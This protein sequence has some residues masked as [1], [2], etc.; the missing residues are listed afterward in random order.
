MVV[1]KL[2]V[3][4]RLATTLGLL[5]LGLLLSWSGDGTTAELPRVVVVATDS[6][7]GFGERV[8][9]ELSLM[10]FDVG[11]ETAPVSELSKEE[12]EQKARVQSAAAIIAI[13][14]VKDGVELRVVDRVTKK[15]LLRNIIDAEQPSDD[16]TV[17]LRAVELLRASLLELSVQDAP[18]G[19]VA[20]P[21]EARE[22]A[23]QPHSEQARKPRETGA[24]NGK[25]ASAERP[26]RVVTF[27]SSGGVLAS[28]GGLPAVP[29]VEFGGTLWLLPRLGTELSL[30]V[31]VSGMS[32]Q[33]LEGTSTTRVSALGVALDW[34]IPLDG[35]RWFADVGAGAAVLLLHTSGAPASRAYFRQET[36][37]IAA[38]PFAQ[39]GLA[40]C[41]GERVRL[42][43][44][45]RVGA[46]LPRFLIRH[47]GRTVARWGRPFALGELG[48][49][50]DL[51]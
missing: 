38:A 1:T 3:K 48:L 13:V 29:S 42:G 8:R 17:A 26:K 36:T 11:F 23:V 33:T 50:V 24:G 22:P 49:E 51:P 4:A 46:A 15:T 35:S 40:Y 14:P 37:A 34:V 12:L 45:A 31:P 39:S 5:W 6:A 28:R 10:G 30:L 20:A 7:P 16:A 41:L 27:R 47:A 32:T 21:M 2:H 44:D 19:D 18:R 25:N 9:A 43:F